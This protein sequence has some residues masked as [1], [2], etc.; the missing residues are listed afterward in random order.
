MVSQVT[1]QN[2]LGNKIKFIYYITDNE[3]DK[4][5]MRVEYSI[6][7]QSKWYNATVINSLPDALNNL[8][9]LLRV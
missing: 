5:W 8:G 4:C 9:S 1:T 7:G 2:L 3:N 6:M